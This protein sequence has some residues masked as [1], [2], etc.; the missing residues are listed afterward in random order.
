MIERRPFDR[1]GHANHGWLNARHHFSFADYYDPERED[2]AGTG[3]VHSEY[4]LEAETTRIFQ[5]WIIPDRRG[6]Q[7]RWG[8]KP[9]PKAERDGRFVTLASG[10]EQDSEALHIRADAEV[11]AVTLKAGQSAEYALENGRRAYLVPATGS[12]EINGVRAE[13]RDGLAVRDEPT[14][15]VTALEDSEV[16]LVEVA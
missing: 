12:I 1:L 4:N 16:L 15:K 3:I 13:A 6:D 9:F 7:P 14:L 11:A 2:S 8:S 5:I 10:D